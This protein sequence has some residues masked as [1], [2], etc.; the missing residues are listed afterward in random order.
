[1]RSRTVIELANATE[2]GL[3]IDLLEA[4]YRA[5]ASGMVVLVLP[6]SLRR[7][8]DRLLDPIVESVGPTTGGVRY[9][10]SSDEPA[11]RAVLASATYAVAA[12]SEFR[13]RCQTSKVPVVGAEAA[14]ARLRAGELAVNADAGSL[15]VRSPEQQVAAAS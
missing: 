11:V 10:D 5:S 12:T 2:A 13:L 14:I 7:L 15:R 1:M 3:P 4:A 9:V 8:V 6:F